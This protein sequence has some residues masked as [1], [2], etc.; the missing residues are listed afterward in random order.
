MSSDALEIAKSL[1]RLRDLCAGDGERLD[2]LEVGDRVG[3]EQGVVTA[4]VDGRGGQRGVEARGDLGDEL[5]GG[6]QHEGAAGR[7]AVRGG[8]GEH[9]LDDRQREG[10]RL[11]GAGLGRAH[12]VAALQHHRNRLR[13]DRR[14]GLVAHF[15]HGALNGGG[16][17]QFGKG[18]GHGHQS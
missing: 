13:L 4:E 15:G 6:R 17:G 11:A 1:S 8:V 14:H 12:H 10:G 7:R 5:A 16:E 2:L 3:D 9:A 18:L